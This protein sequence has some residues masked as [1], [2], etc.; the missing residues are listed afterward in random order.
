MTH[1]GAQRACYRNITAFIHETLNALS[2]VRL[3]WKYADPFDFNQFYSPLNLDLL[4]MLVQHCFSLTINFYVLSGRDLQLIICHNPQRAALDSE[5]TSY[6]QGLNKKLRHE[7][8][9]S[10]LRGTKHECPW[11]SSLAGF[12]FSPQRERRIDNS[13]RFEKLAADSI[14]KL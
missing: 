12:W 14:Q 6:T 7:N 11:K 4:L 1:R 5:Q 13:R 10:S 3:L 9:Q 2:H 8:N